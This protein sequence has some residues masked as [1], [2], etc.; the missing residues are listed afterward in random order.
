MKISM[1][2]MHTILKA[3]N[4]K[5]DH[6]SIY[7]DGNIL[8]DSPLVFGVNWG[9][10]GTV[11]PNKANE[12]GR[13]LQKASSVANALNGM[14]LERI[15]KESEILGENEWT[16]GFLERIHREDVSASEIVAAVEHIILRN[17]PIDRLF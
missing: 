7:E 16:E 13:E 3:I 10:F 11:D 8:G 12:F 2:A 6:I 15:Y 14:E 5:F 1:V 17:I 9:C 4:E